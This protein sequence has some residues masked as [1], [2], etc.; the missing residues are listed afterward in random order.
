MN[1][2]LNF[3]LSKTFDETNEYKLLTCN[4][5]NSDIFNF[6]EDIDYSKL[7]NAYYEIKK[8]IESK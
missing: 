4:L 8:L 3:N 7:S 5:D 2:Y 6:I 1:N